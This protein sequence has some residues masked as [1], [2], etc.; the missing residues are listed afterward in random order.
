MKPFEACLLR[1]G[2]TITFG[3][4][5]RTYKLTG[6][7]TGI[8]S[9]WDAGDSDEGDSVAKGSKRPFQ[10]PIHAKK[11]EKKKRRW[12][13]G[14]KASSKMTENERVAQM[15]GSGSGCFGPGFD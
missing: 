4:S 14:P 13:N 8:S 6:T 2:S 3:A 5:A 9:S 11:W 15:A 10:P 1:E 7:A 12:L